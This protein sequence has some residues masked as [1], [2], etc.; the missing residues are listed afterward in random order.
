MMIGSIVTEPRSRSSSHGKASVQEI[1]VGEK[2]RLIFG[3]QRMEKWELC[4]QLN[5]ST[6]GNCRVTAKQ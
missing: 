2:E 3:S 1:S 5:F 4:S 6:A